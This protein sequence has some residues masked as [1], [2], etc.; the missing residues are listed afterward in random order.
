MEDDCICSAVWSRRETTSVGVCSITAC[1]LLSRSGGELGFSG[2]SNQFW[3]SLRGRNDEKGLFLFGG[4]K[5]KN[6]WAYRLQM[7]AR[8][9]GTPVWI[10]FCCLIDFIKLLFQGKIWCFAFVCFRGFSPKQ[11]LL[12]EHVRSS[13]CLEVSKLQI[14]MSKQ[15]CQSMGEAITVLQFICW[16]ADASPWKQRLEADES[17]PAENFRALRNSKVCLRVRKVLGAWNRMFVCVFCFFLSLYS[18]FFLLFSPRRRPVPCKSS[19]NRALFRT[20]IWR[21]LRVSLCAWGIRR[22]MPITI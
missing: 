13:S 21:C 2:D 10:L 5:M 20:Q 7:S 1:T 19:V 4:R 22:A 6:I 11:S 16:L 8:D 18:A 15:L 3:T 14:L 9:L 17:D 12:T